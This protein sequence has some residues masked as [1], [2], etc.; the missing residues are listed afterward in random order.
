MAV[1]VLGVLVVMVLVGVIVWLLFLTPVT[2]EWS[3]GISG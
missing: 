1:A 3:G 2:Y